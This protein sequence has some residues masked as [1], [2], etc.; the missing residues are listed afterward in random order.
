MEPQFTY[1]QLQ[2]DN[3]VSSFNR[4]GKVTIV[5]DS[6]KGKAL[7]A[8]LTNLNRIRAISPQKRAFLQLRLSI[9]GLIL[10]VRIL[11]FHSRLF[12]VFGFYNEVLP[13]Y[14]LQRNPQ[15]NFL[16]VFRANKP[17]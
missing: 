14:T 5:L 7:Q 2:H 13:V 9:V 10:T 3:L 1:D 11:L 15:N 16:F 4:D 6:K 8:L 12:H 17:S